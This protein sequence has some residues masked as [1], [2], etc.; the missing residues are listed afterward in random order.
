MTVRSS[1]GSALS[2]LGACA[3]LAFAAGWSIAACADDLVVAPPPGARGADAKFRLLYD[4]P[5]VWPASVLMRY[6][7]SGAPPTFA[8]ASVTSAVLESALAKWRAVC[9]IDIAYAGLTGVVPESTVV[10]AENG[11]QPDQVNV[12]GWKATPS[13]IS[14]YTV[15][16]PGIAESGY[17][18]ILDADV[19][20]DPVKVSASPQLTRLLVHEIGHVLGLN[21]AQFD[22]TMMSGPPYSV[23]NTL[24]NLTTDD[25]RGCRCLYGLPAGVTTGLLCTPPPILDFGQVAAG[26][27]AQR[28]IPVVNNGN[29]STTIASV[30]PSASYQTSGCAPGTVLPP[31]GACTITVTFA[32]AT[33]GDH[34]GSVDIV[35]SE[36]GSYKVKLLGAASGGAGSPYSVDIEQLD[37]GEIAIGAPASTQR[38]RFTNVSG[39]ATSIS[40]MLF[41]GEQSND[42]SRSGACKVGQPMQPGGYCTVDIGFK[43]SAAGERRAQFVVEVGSGARSTVSAKGTGKSATGTSEPVVA[44]PVPVVEYYHSGIDHYFITIAPDEIAAL[45]SGLL[46]GWSRT[47]LSF[48]AHAQSQP[49]YAPICRFYLPPPAASHFYSANPQECAVVQAGNPSFV[50]ESTSV[51]QLASPNPISGVCPAGTVAVYR[52]WNARADTNHRYTTSAALRNQMVAQG[53]VAEGYGPDAVIFCAPQ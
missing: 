8:D 17:A 43:P 3:A 36:P 52:V 35:A 5:A 12:V 25:I 20:V 27:T 19:I 7:P 48:K 28:S 39:S 14:G 34:G 4:P 22:G 41:E 46:Q 37:F 49:G 30:T 11:P 16:S 9:P 47:G 26:A 15:G 13:G 2:R 32:P 10:D 51:M 38:V 24:D 1:S 53:Y 50:L 44:V 29:A 42:F 18:P 23:Y 31:G 21:H 45:D 6:N 33:G 40:A